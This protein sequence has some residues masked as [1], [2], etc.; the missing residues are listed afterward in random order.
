M[1]AVIDI[2]SNSVR[3]FVECGRAVTPKLLNTTRLAENLAITGRLDENAM[4]RTKNAVADFFAAAKRQGAD[5]VFVF[6]TEAMRCPGGERLKTMIE[7]DVPVNVDIISGKEEALTGYLGATGGK[8]SHAVVDIGGAS[9]ELI[10][11]KNETVEYAES[12]KLGVVRLKDTLGD[13]REDIENFCRGAVKAYRA[14]KADNLIGIGGTA[15]SLAS[16]AQ[17]QSRYDAEAV[18]GSV[19]RRDALSELTDRIFA[20]RDITADFPSIDRKR[21]DVIGHGAVLLGAIMDRLGFDRITVS[22]HDNIEGYLLLKR[23]GANALK[24]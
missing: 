9:V 8:G 7:A 13:R 1:D 17:N 16:M 12:L 5:N 2:G 18:H 3:L 20:C 24:R 11:G 19:I 23:R 21:A 14:V 15:T 6:G 22:E 10:A 4:V